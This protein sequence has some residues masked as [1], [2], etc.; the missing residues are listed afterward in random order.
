M[1]TH[2]LPAKGALKRE[3]EMGLLSDYLEHIPQNRQAQWERILGEVLSFGPDSLEAHDLLEVLHVT[4]VR[5]YREY[6]DFDQ[7]DTRMT[8]LEKALEEFDGEP[9]RKKNDEDWAYEDHI[10]RRVL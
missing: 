5:R 9:P 1:I 10:A 2:R 4:Q 6:P 3:M 8:F 7:I